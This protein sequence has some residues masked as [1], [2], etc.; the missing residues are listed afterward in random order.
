MA[1]RTNY[2]DL[3]K[4]L[5]TPRTLEEQYLYGLICSV[6][7]VDYPNMA[8]TSPFTRMEQYWKAFYEVAGYKFKDLETP[9]EN[10]VNS[11]AIQANA[12]T[13]AKLANNSVVSSK[14]ANASVTNSKLADSSV[15]ISKLDNDIE[16][17]LL[18]DNRITEP[19]LKQSV[20]EKLLGYQNVTTDNLADGCVTKEKISADI[21]LDGEK[22]VIEVVKRNG[23][24]LPVTNKTVDIVV[25]TRT[26]QLIND[27]GF[28]SGSGGTVITYDDTELRGLINDKQDKLNTSQ[29]ANIN[30]DHSK[31]LTQHQSLTGYAT[32][33]WVEGKGYLTSHQDI[34]GK[35]DA[36]ALSTVATTG[37]YNDLTNKP[38]LFD[39]NYN[40]LSNKPTLFDGNYNSLSNKPTIPT[41]PTNVSAFT[42][43]VG[44][45]TTHQ[46]LNGYATESWVNNQGFLTEHQSL[47]AY[48]L[49]T[50]LPTVPTNV[51][52]FN[53]DSG[54]L[55]EHQDISGKVDKTGDTMTGDLTISGAKSTLA[56]S[57]GLK[58]GSGC[59]IA[60]NSS[61]LLGIANSSHTLVFNSGDLRPTSNDTINIGN[62][63]NP[64]DNGYF[65]TS[66]KIN[67]K[68]VATQ[69]WVESLLG[70]IENGSY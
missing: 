62:S 17:R 27:S 31:Y 63:S 68:D 18:G 56:T 44:Y 12:I 47:S 45:L 54:Y 58:F 46:S 13:T 69:E 11:A 30:A 19:M 22:N 49:K 50:E 36:S 34:S 55:T 4:S 15:T 59:Y 64:F 8:K 21:K 43:D 52:E 10:K 61:G 20:Q 16:A 1:L 35:V 25:P 42:N 24:A 2:D 57:K 7:E 23:V 14:I 67:G 38:S 51:S 6:A 39:G 26:S 48:A 65:K 32:E 28:G 70:D 9:A 40:S 66:I 29:L 33:S 60:Q 5:P 3:V 37:N 53:N 41:V